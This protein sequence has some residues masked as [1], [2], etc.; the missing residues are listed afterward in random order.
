MKKGRITRK[1]IT[2]LPI[3]GLC[4]LIYIFWHFHSLGNH[5]SEELVK[6][7]LNKMG[8]WAPLGFIIFQMIQVFAPILPGGLSILIGALL[9]GNI[10]GIIYSYIGGVIGEI[11]G[12]EI[13]RKIG[14][15]LLP[16]IFSPR[17]YN[18]YEKIANEQ[19]VN[20]EK[21]LIIT[22]IV[23]FLPDDIACLVSGLSKMKFSHYFIIILLLKP[24]SIALYSYFLLFVYHR[25]F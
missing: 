1:I 3:L 15:G 21:I 5:H 13:V 22:L 14:N 18:K 20:M 23:P 19:S 6:K 8:P 11:I 25:I 7:I 12:F 9:F 16:Y 2:I 24:W 17:V 10:L 4:V